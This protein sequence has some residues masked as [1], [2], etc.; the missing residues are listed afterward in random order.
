M[1][2][3][4]RKSAG[5]WMIKILLG[6]IVVAFVFMGA[7]SFYSRRGAEVARVNGEPISVKEY[8]QTYHNIIRNMEQRFGGQIDQE[9]IESLN[10]RQQALDRLIEKHLL[11]QVAKKN[12]ITVPDQI[13]A[14]SITGISAFQNQ[15]RFDPQLYRR[16][17][18][19]NN[20]S[21]ES[22]ESLQKQ[23][24]ITSVI[25]NSVGNSLPVSESEARAWYDWKNTKVK[26]N[27]AQFAA[28]DFE[29][30]EVT[31]NEIQQYFEKNRED[32]K[33]EPKIKARY[34]RFTPQN[35]LSRVEVSEEEIKN[36]YQAHQSE[37]TSTETVE[38]RHILLK[39]PENADKNTEEQVRKKALEI[40]E[41][42]RS[43][44]DFS[45]LAEKFSEGPSAS[46]GGYLGTLE[47]G[48]AVKPFSEKAF[49]MKAGEIS[50]PVRTR[51][52][53]HVIKVEKHRQAS[54]KP[55]EKVKEKIREK[56]ALQKADNIAYEEAYSMYNISFGGEDLVKNTRDLDI[57]LETTGFFTQNRG[58]SGIENSAGFAETAFSIPLMEISGVKNIGNSY[59]LIQPIEK[60]EPHIPELSSIIEK[61]RADARREKQK[62][63]AKKA[64]KNLLEKISADGSLTE[65]AGK[66]G[67]ETGT[68][69]FFKRGEPV[70]D[71]GQSRQIAS[72][73]FSLS[74]SN[75]VSDSVIARED[76]FY[77]IGLQ[78]RKAPSDEGFQAEKKT[79]MARLEARKH[80]QAVNRW[81]TALRQSSNIEISDQFSNLSGSG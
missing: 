8:Q 19:R 30:V 73:A 56:L 25:R 39:V 51:F 80:R 66:S 60:Q 55:L 27:Y 28:K 77:V 31:K 35:Y 68:T 72:A 1:L 65:A 29:N 36:Y 21:P 61:V 37:F 10:I 41:R 76:S 64:A 12:N 63:A 40:M 47:K 42:A 34:V 26:I 38:A 69:D 32:Y 44:R 16:V 9:M 15:G 67:I 14:S 79:V 18:N 22:F 57:D 5:S 3:S 13:L 2:S 33:T 6:L 52:G 7:G 81:L 46:E 71:I 58:P 48:D 17:L 74:S 23:A 53:W 24:I 49:S 54:A 62:Q 4:M 50:E 78:A 45:A 70:P 11:I 59:F 20:L 43:G 75:P